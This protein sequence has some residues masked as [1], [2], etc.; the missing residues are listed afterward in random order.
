MSV[1]YHSEDSQPIL[2][3]GIIFFF[4]LR[5]ARNVDAVFICLVFI[6]LG[7]HIFGK[8]FAASLQ[9]FHEAFK[10]PLAS[11]LFFLNLTAFL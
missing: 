4:C 11:F 6:S 1:Y 3:V 10:D 9:Y 7:N 5:L 8:S 2:K